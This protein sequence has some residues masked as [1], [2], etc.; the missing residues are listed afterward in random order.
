MSDNNNNQQAPLTNAPGLGQRVVG[1]VLPTILT[2]LIAIGAGGIQLNLKTNQQNTEAIVND[3]RKEMVR[4]ER[5]RKA[6]ND[7]LYIE[8]TKNDATPVPEQ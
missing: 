4:L 1:W 6:L 3:L 5:E 2:G 8:K 7:K